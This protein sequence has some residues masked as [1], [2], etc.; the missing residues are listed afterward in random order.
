MKHTV[1]SVESQ[2]IE[3]LFQLWRPELASDSKA[4]EAFEN[5]FR[6][7]SYVDVE[8]LRRDYFLYSFL[9]KWKGIR[10]EGFDPERTAFETWKQCEHQCGFTNGFLTHQKV[11]GQYWLPLSVISA[12]QRK[13]AAV[14]GKPNWELLSTLCRFGNGATATLRRGKTH[15][16]KS[17]RP[18]ITADAIPYACIVLTDD[19]WL[20]DKVGGL[21]DL[22]VVRSNRMEMVP[23]TSKTHRPIACEPTLNGFIQ[24][25]IGRYIRSRLKK[26]GVDLDDQTI[27]QDLAK[28]A[29]AEGFATIDLSSA[30]DT[31]SRAL[32][33][34]LLP[35]NWF[36]ILDD[37][38]SRTTT[39]KGQTYYLEKFSSMGNAFTFELESL[40]FWALVSASTESEWCSVYGDDIIVKQSDAETVIKTLKWAGFTINVDKSFIKG[41]FFESCG[42]H[43]LYG[44]EVTPPFQKDVCA[45]PI[46]YVRLHNRIVRAGIRLDLP[47]VEFA[48]ARIRDLYRS[49]FGK[50]AQTGPTVEYDEFFINPDFVWGDRDRVNIVSL[51][52]MSRFRTNLPLWRDEVYLGLRLRTGSSFGT[53]PQGHC[54][55]PLREVLREIRKTH[56]RSSCAS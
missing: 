49:S 21:R 11:T 26:F 10:I 32:V 18:S 41:C 46:D 9:R 2:A 45:Q 42:K 17:L 23:K 34:L 24:Q 39:Y 20:Q 44:E 8:S 16:D 29:Y 48:A 52:T 40:I 38:R 27:N 14:L 51:V 37:L 30:S 56:W 19:A 22:N 13:V 1:D 55:E 35:P 7:D 4:R 47:E 12:A 31:L 25:G 3:I 36:E 43:Y 50:R 6:P 54:A 33:E 53:D 28:R 5:N 15:A